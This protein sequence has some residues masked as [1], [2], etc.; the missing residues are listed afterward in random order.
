MWLR[1]DFVVD[2]W[3]LGGQ[4]VCH[5]ILPC[6]L[7]KFCLFAQTLYHY[8]LDSYVLRLSCTSIAVQNSLLYNASDEINFRILKILKSNQEILKSVDAKGGRCCSHK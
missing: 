7:P 6:T 4:T 2:Q 8:L 3:D 5:C 1:M